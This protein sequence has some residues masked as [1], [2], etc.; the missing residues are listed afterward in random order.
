M[1][2]IVCCAVLLG[3]GISGV[4]AA[5]GVS[6]FANDRRGEWAPMTAPICVG[7]GLLLCGFDAQRL[8]GSH[9][10]TRWKLGLATVIVVCVSCVW[11]TWRF[12][13]RV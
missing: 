1:L 8:I 3:A 5:Y 10:Y 9:G 7:A 6:D 4:L 13:D 2:A 11:C 12:S